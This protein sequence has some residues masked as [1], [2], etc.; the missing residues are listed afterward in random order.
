MFIT[1]L[2]SIKLIKNLSQAQLDAPDAL[3]VPVAHF[4]GV[5]A[6]SGQ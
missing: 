2:N 1:K 3:V 6:P 5:V 4:I